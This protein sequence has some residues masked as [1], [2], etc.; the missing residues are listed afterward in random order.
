[1]IIIKNY[2]KTAESSKAQT[3]IDSLNGKSKAVKKTK[4][5]KIKSKLEDKKA[6]KKNSNKRAMNMGPPSIK[7]SAKGINQVK[8]KNTIQKQP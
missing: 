7:S 4:N 1:M 2:P 6:P 8:N 5:T 3:I